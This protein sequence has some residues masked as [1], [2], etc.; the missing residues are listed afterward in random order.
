MIKI[1][2][3]SKLE[4][5]NLLSSKKYSIATHVISDVKKVA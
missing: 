5:L 2:F 4:N 1:N 3:K